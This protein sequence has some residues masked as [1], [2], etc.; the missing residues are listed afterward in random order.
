MKSKLSSILLAVAVAFG[1]WMYVITS[2]SPGS[3]ETIY[4]I[5]VVLTGETALK[6]RG[7]MV[8]GV[9]NTSV[10]MTLSGNRSDLIKVNRGNIT[11]KADL[12]T[13]TE[14]GENIPLTY[15]HA[16]PGDVPSDAFVVENK[17][18][19]VI[20]VTV[21]ER[22]IKE[23]PVEVVWTGSVPDG[24]MCDRENKV[25]DYTSVSVDGPAS[26]ADRITKAV[27]EVDLSEQRESI[28]QSY[29]YTLCDEEGN[30]VDAEMITTNVAEVNLQVRIQ[31]VK[32]L[33]LDLDITYGGGATPD[34]TVIKI[35]P[36]TIRVSGGEA[37]LD[38]L[39][40]EWTLGKL[41]LAE[42]TRSQDG[43]TFQITLPEGVTNETGTTEAAVSIQF[44]GLST[45][46]FT[47]ENISAINVP[48]G[49]E[50]DLITQE[51]T[52]VLRGPSADVAKVQVED[53]IATVDFTDE[54]VG[55]NTFKVNIECTDE[56]STVGAVGTYSVSATVKE[57]QVP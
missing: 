21:E 1:L 10:T 36:E 46:E 4:D 26:V 16:F 7:L 3:E 47:I 55:T 44:T 40:D 48:E 12:S 54:E 39:G 52:V 15:T 35:L 37:V 28:D 49:M 31:Q 56:F 13:I 5:P 23:V 25:L 6:E 34:N 27:I 24:F 45:R 20:Y 9:S 17:S 19:D 53:I 43:M 32:E 29:R 51:L 11:L 18:P 57:K 14:A 8:M 33:K 50:V 38:K 30:G 22:V 42:I 2:V 41:N